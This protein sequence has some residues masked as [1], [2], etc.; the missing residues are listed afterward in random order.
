MVIKNISKKIKDVT[1]LGDGKHHYQ[2]AFDFIKE[3]NYKQAISFFEIASKKFKNEK[4]Q[5]MNKRTRANILI[6][7]YQDTHKKDEKVALIK[8]IVT[9]L[10]ELEQIE[11]MD[12]PYNLV[13]CDEIIERLTNERNKLVAT[14]SERAWSD[15][16]YEQDTR[17]EKIEKSLRKIEG[18]KMQTI[19]NDLMKA[20]LSSKEQ[21]HQLEYSE[22]IIEAFKKLGP[23]EKIE[24]L[25]KSVETERIIMEAEGRRNEIKAH[26]EKNHIDKVKL[27]QDAAQVFKK[28]GRK[29]L[30]TFKYLVY[31]NHTNN[32]E[33]R[34]FFNLANAL[35]YEAIHEA[36]VSFDFGN[37]IKKLENSAKLFSDC[38][39]EEWRIQCEKII[40]S[41]SKRATC[42]ICKN[43]VQGQRIN[44]NEYPITIS[45]Y[46]KHL[47]KEN[48]KLTTSFNLEENKVILC[49]LCSLLLQ[50][51]VA[52]QVNKI[53]KKS[54]ERLALEK[55]EEK[56][57]NLKLYLD[58][59]I[60]EE[61]EELK[62][63]KEEFYDLK[64]KTLKDLNP[65]KDIDIKTKDLTNLD[66]KET[67]E[68]NIGKDVDLGLEN[69]TA[70]D[71]EEELEDK[72]GTKKDEL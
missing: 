68:E 70:I 57:E 15:Q 48:D 26:M 14:I 4:N 52:G 49:K 60:K 43:E 62:K 27:Y 20:Y 67:L 55:L 53:S 58:E 31:D 44:F 61:K 11:E 39:N 56:G 71:L 33:E 24:A 38:N 25:E 30:F 46:F 19:A 1:G 2:R 6:C 22:K 51:V 37:V 32:G 65:I 34:Y 45:S 50:N 5:L 9:N 69:L 35:F 72:G 63:L 21:E 36:K 3:R 17:I 16:E 10:K 29:E 66:L 23:I 18:D 54:F 40:K 42:W 64:A 12:P 8:D 13:Y 47:L 41:L 59:S 28:I 7:K